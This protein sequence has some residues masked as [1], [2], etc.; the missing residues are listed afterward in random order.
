MLPA[1]AK[2]N[3]DLHVGRALPDG[4]HEIATTM[5]TIA[6]HDLLEISKA[7]ATSLSVEGLKVPA[8]P[9]N[10]VLKAQHALQ[11]AVAHDLPAQ[12]VLHK[13]IP[14]GSGFGGAS[15]DAAAALRGLKSLYRLDVDLMQVAAGVGADVPF[16]L[17]G[18]RARAEGRGERLTTLETP[19]QWFAL[20]WPRIELSTAAVYRAW[21]EM[22]GEG[23][24]ELQR[25]AQHVDSRVGDFATSLGSEWQMTGSGSA[26]YK[27]C[28]S[29]EEAE[30][31][32]ARIDHAWT[33]VTCAIGAT[34]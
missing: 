7:P 27:P 26:F 1:R 16:F 30:T 3:L 13:R 18:G 28:A 19:H 34:A 2:L 24:N 6:L 21:D 12:F 32:V 5:Q 10:A 17:H 25:A 11:R 14:P 20:A 33:A 22:K 15:S 9:E 29:K 31:A 8:G 23:R 4:Y